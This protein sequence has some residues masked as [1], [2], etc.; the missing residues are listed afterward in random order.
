MIYYL[1]SEII[2]DQPGNLFSSKVNLDSVSILTRD[3]CSL[4]P[5]HQLSSSE[6]ECL[7][8]IFQHR[9][10]WNMILRSIS[11]F[12]FPEN[13]TSQANTGK[14]GKLAIDFSFVL[15]KCFFFQSWIKIDNEEVGWDGSLHTCFWIGSNIFKDISNFFLNFF[16]EF[17]KSFLNFSQ[18]FFHFFFKFFFLNFSRC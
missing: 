4:A 15:P 9:K 17:S 14:H 10:A 8:F 2:S 18:L 3:F 7:F 13:M 5:K 1:H 16:Q 6:I 12:A 11:Y